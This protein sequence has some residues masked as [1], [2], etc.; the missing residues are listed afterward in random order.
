MEL[1]KAKEDGGGGPSLAVEQIRRLLA[2][3]RRE[4]A[5]VALAELRRRH[6]DFQLPP[7]LQALR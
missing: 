3:G 1:G 6:P 2:A 7:D 5:L 4:D